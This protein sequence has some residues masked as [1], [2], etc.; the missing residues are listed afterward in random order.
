M[1]MMAKEKYIYLSGEQGRL[2]EISIRLR[3][4][5]SGTALNIS[6][7]VVDNYG[8]PDHKFM[9]RTTTTT[10]LAEFN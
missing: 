2:D 5:E 8:R 9:G 1:M 4:R 10:L 6:L 3:M 7:L